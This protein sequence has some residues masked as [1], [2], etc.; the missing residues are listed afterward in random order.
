[1]ANR[2]PMKAMRAKCLDCCCGQI[3]EVRLCK[4]EKCP[5]HEYRMGRR[6]KKDMD[7]ELSAEDEQSAE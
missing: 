7:V 4:V 3:V 6:P 1:M 5:L 2:T